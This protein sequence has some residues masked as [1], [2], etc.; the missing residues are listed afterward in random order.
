[1]VVVDA[2]VWTARL[3]AQD[4]FHAPAS[5]WMAERRAENTL[6]V[7]PSL[8]LAEVA[9]AISRRTGDRALAERALQAL[10]QLPGLRLVEMENALALSAGKLAA[11]LGLRGA[12]AIYVAVA[13]TLDLPLC[14]LDEEQARRAAYRVTIQR[15]QP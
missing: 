3:V 11:S 2:S 9:G 12:D 6:L 15:F 1:M 13:E 8:M 10:I 4:I 5:R 7:S 14:T